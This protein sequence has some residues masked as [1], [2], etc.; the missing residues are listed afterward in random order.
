[1]IKLRLCGIL[2]LLNMSLTFLNN[3]GLNN[4]ECDIYELLVKTGEVPVSKLIELSK[5]KRPTIYKALQTLEKKGL[6]L[7]RDIH[8]KIHI[9]PE[10]PAKLQ[11][12]ADEKFEQIKQVREN[13]N[14]LIPGLALSYTNSTERPIVKIFEGISGLKKIYEDLLVDSKPVS[15]ILQAATVEPELYNW[16]TTKFVKKRVR[17][18][19]HVKAIVASSRA[20]KLYLQNSPKE[21][22]IAKQV[23]SGQFPFQHEIDIYGDKVAVINYKKDEPLIGLIIQHPQIALTMKAWFDLTWSNLD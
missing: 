16:L 17:A 2:R 13:L 12:L 15:A 21:Y 6:V 11:Q 18:K 5:L 22:R 4:T 23:D 8:K 1:M 19:I 7:K 10:S 20:S 14:S 9:S 3:I